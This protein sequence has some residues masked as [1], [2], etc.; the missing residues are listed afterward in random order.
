MHETAKIFLGA[1]FFALPLV[2][3]PPSGSKPKI[4]GT[5]QTDN[6]LMLRRIN[7]A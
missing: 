4:D 3:L 6:F 1:V 2:M 5:Q 7:V